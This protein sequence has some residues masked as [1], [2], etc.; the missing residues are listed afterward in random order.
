MSTEYR[1]RVIVEERRV[2]QPES[3]SPKKRSRWAKTGVGQ[4]SVFSEDQAAQFDL[5]DKLV[6]IVAA[7]NREKTAETR[8]AIKAL[9]EKS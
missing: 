3:W 7:D 5:Y 9:L 8:D 4:E 6:E 1:V 2:S